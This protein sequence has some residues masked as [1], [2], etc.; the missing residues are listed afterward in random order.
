MRAPSKVAPE[1]LAPE[2][3]AWLTKSTDLT[4]RSLRDLVSRA[5][6][7]NSMVDIAKTKSAAELEYKLSESAEFLECTPTVRSQLRRAS[8][9][10]KDFLGQ[11][12]K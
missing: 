3:S 6:R 2:F 8:K 11:R 5:R 1:L 9:L 4:T 7:V 10:Y 12:K